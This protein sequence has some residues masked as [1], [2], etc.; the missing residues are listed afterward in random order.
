MITVTFNRISLAIGS[1]ISP[2][3]F[4]LYYK[5]ISDA[6]YT[7]IEGGVYVDEDGYI[8]SSPLPSISV[9]ETGTYIF[10]AVNDFCGAIYYQQFYINNTNLYEWV[11]DDG[12]C[13]QSTPLNLFDSVTGFADP[14]D[15]GYDAASGMMYVV[16]ASAVTSGSNIYW[17]DPYSIASESD[18]T[19][20]GSLNYFAIASIMDMENRK[21]YIAGSDTGGLVRYDIATDSVST[22]PYGTDDVYTRLYLLKITDSIY[23]SIDMT[24]Q[25]VYFLDI[26]AF[27]VSDSTL[28]SAIPDANKYMSDGTYIL[29][30]NG[31]YWVIQSRGSSGPSYEDTIGRYNS[32]FDTLIGTIALP[33]QQTWDN[34]SY[35]RNVFL[36]GTNLFIFDMGSCQLMKVDTNTLI[37]EVVHEFTNREGKTNASMSVIRD[38]VSFD[39]FISGDYRNTAADSSAIPVT[40]KLDNITYEPIVI[41]PGL[42][43]GGV[44]KRVGLSDILVSAYVGSQLVYPT[45]PPGAATDGTIS[46]FTKSGTG[47]NTGMFIWV[48]I[49]KVNTVTGVPTGDV[50]L[51]TPGEPNYIPPFEDLATCPVTYTELCPDVPATFTGADAEYEYSLD[52]STYNNPVIDHID[53]QQVD[54]VTTIVV[55]TTTVA[56]NLYQNGTLTKVGA[57]PNRV[58]LLFKDAANNTLSTCTNVFTIP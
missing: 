8:L 37:V 18:V 43:Y 51:N 41:Y 48:T 44:M 53:L 28:F 50:A 4:T 42:A 23:A 22:L 19:P 20:V 58:D 24:E 35:W 39:L 12:Y 38:E 57:N 1:V 21:I 31:E 52:P 33:G 46:M 16:D 27:V 40:Y 3:P 15:V 26:D 55:A 56:K 25:R 29:F 7:L 49:Q 2:T 5:L 17:F 11:G 32:D 9:D 47:N 14:R 13:E 30:I 6:D 36:E 45:N 54:T 10:K 34:N